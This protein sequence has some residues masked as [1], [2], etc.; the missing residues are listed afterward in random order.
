MEKTWNEFI[1]RQVEATLKG[2]RIH[3]EIWRPQPGFIA[4]ISEGSLAPELRKGN[5]GEGLVWLYVFGSPWGV[6]GVQYW[7][8]NLTER[9]VLYVY[10]RP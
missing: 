2:E 1:V 5:R 8:V 4:A 10:I 9:R 6:P 7:F 3:S